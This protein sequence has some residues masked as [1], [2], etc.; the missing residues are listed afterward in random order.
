M[1]ISEQQIYDAAPLF[2][3]LK[4]EGY[5]DPDDSMAPDI[6][7][8][9]TELGLGAHVQEK[10]YPPIHYWG[11]ECGQGWFDIVR[12]A[13]TKIEVLLNA[14]VTAGTAVD[15]LPGCTQIKEKFGGLRLGWRAVEAV[16]ITQPMQSV[17]AQAEEL[18]LRTCALCG[19]PGTRRPNLGFSPYCDACARTKTIRANGAQQISGNTF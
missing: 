14:M 2:F 13:A 1:Q 7:A 3:R 15:D 12:D 16:P 5:F 8:I 19:E 4:T 18:A 10:Q 6:Q 11:I 9:R 17:I